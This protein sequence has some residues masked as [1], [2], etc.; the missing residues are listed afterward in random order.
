MLIT[1]MVF[2][3]LAMFIS[4]WDLSHVRFSESRIFMALTM[5]GIMGLLMFFWMSKMYNNFKANIAIIVLSLLLLTGGVLLDRSQITV[6]DTYY[7]KAM[8]PHHSM[9]ITRSEKAQIKDMRV[10]KL[11][12]QIS[13][14]QRQEIL[15]MDWLIKDIEQN[16]LALDKEEA[17]RRQLPEFIVSSSRNCF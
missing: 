6:N 4:S 12:S 1:S 7:M 3:Y 17:L 15:E 11:A 2:M 8:I 9:A 16:G 14:A 10:C 5:G 13:E